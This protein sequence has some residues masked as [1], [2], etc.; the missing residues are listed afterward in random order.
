MEEPVD[1]LAPNVPPPP[2][3]APPASR[4]TGP[5]PP[6][7]G[8]R[9]AA[10]RSLTSIRSKVISRSAGYIAI[11][12]ACAAAVFLLLG[13]LGYYSIPFII[14]HLPSGYG[15]LIL[16]LEFTTFSYVLGMGVAFGLGLVR[17]HTPT[18]KSAGAGRSA[19]ADGSPSSGSGLSTGSL[20]RTLRSSEAPHS[21]SRCSSS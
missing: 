11:G 9:S 21:W 13:F 16:S 15:P 10:S 6:P 4:T 3:D 14:Q 12:V 1:R 20:P 19:G 18:S 17:A 8:R 7:R 5:L 2:G